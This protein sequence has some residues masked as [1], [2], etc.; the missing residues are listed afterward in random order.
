MNATVRDNI[1][2]GDSEDLFDKA[3]YDRAIEMSCLDADI[4]NFVDAD[5][6]EIGEKGINLSGGQRQ[7]VSL[8]RALYSDAQILVLDDCKKKKKTEIS[9]F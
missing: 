7:R 6:T 1:L 2:F 5:L 9:F 3:R 4:R 8:A